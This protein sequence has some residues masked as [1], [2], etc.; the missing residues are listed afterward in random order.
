M[1]KNYNKIEHLELLKK[2]K[3]VNLNSEDS[4]KCLHYSSMTNGCLDWC[5][6]DNYLE[7]LE[8]F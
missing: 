6:R 2:R 5:I 4:Q 7:L 1:D 3:S 8:D